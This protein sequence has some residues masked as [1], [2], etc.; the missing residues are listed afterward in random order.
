MPT[1]RLSSIFTSNATS[2]F[3]A[4]SPQP[5]A[6]LAALAVATERVRAG[7]L[8]REDAHHLF[9]ELLRQATPVP[10]RSLNGF[11]AAL[12][13]APASATCRRDGPALALAL[14]NRVCREEAGPQVASSWAASAVRIART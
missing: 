12:A 4:P 8:S 9:D 6:P 10:S 13:R 2:S 11:L 1:G 14:F 3:R 5:R 7:T